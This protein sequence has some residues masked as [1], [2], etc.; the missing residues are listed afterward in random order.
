MANPWSLVNKLAMAASVSCMSHTTESDLATIA[1]LA[2]GDRGLAIVS[3]AR[4]DAT[5]HSS[6]VNAGLTKHPV[7]GSDVVAFVVHGTAHKL[8]LLAAQPHATVAWRV[9]WNWASVD[10]PVQLCGPKHPLEGFD[11]A[12]L[13]QLLRKVFSDAGGTHDNWPEY[14]R[15]MATEKRTVVMVKPH[16]TIG[17]G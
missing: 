3:I 6:L 10:G 11:Q 9:G 1:R 15:V 8:K 7:D 13:P 12:D 4:S 16:R 2:G 5:V 17:V 14:D